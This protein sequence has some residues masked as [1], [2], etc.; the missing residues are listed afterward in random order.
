MWW[1]RDNERERGLTTEDDWVNLSIIPQGPQN[2]TGQ[3]HRVYELSSRG[4][5]APDLQGFLVPWTTD[6]RR[7]EWL[8]RHDQLLQHRTGMKSVATGLFQPNKQVKCEDVFGFLVEISATWTWLTFSEVSF[9]YEARQHVSVCQAEVV[10]RT[11][12]VCRDHSRVVSS[13]LL[14]IPPAKHTELCRRA[15]ISQPVNLLKTK[16]FLPVEDDDHS[17]RVWIPIVWVVRWS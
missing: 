2:E 4:A 14:V 9:V 15:S 6:T 10:V 16:I 1:I 3:V 12:H 8:D 11:K 5:G 13:M 17:L 7:C